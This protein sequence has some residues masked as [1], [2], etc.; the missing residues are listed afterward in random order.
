MTNSANHLR[1][2][3]FYCSV[4]ELKL[5]IE[6]RFKGQIISCPKCKVDF[7]APKPS[8]PAGT[9]IGD[10]RLDALIGSGSMAEVYS[11][12]HKLMDRW[13]AIKIIKQKKLDLE[14]RLRFQRE[15]QCLSRFHHPHFVGVVYA[16][17]YHDDYYL[18]MDLIKGKTCKELSVIEGPFKVK[19]SLTY[20]L[21]IAEA[22][23]YAWDQ[24][25]LLHRDI[26]PSNIMVDTKKDFALL[27]DLG[28]SKSL[29][30][31]SDL[32]KIDMVLGSPYYMS[33]EQAA[34][35]ELDQRSDIYALGATLYH[36]LSGAPPFDGQSPMEV[37]VAKTDTLPTPLI[38]LC[39][40]LPK[41]IHDL[42]SYL[43]EFK[44][45]DRPADWD[46]VIE[47]LKN[48]LKKSADHSKKA[49]YKKAKTSGSTMKLSMSTGKQKSAKRKTP[50]REVSK[51]KPVETKKT[52]FSLFKKRN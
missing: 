10:F 31:E 44:L 47:L 45:V 25:K 6:E 36:F 33:P 28:I 1:D 35:K 16:G 22:M 14:E 41:T 21:Q 42:V 52:P 4:C 32:T 9:Y 40:D 2:F 50:P 7:H 34:N 15:I 46:E 24:L 30:V 39:P 43:M 13:V 12:Y 3:K 29:A 48:A 38:D 27:T 51:E 17:E 11:A 19:R 23:K 18:A 5:S 49:P 26:K 20:C 8:Y 37:L